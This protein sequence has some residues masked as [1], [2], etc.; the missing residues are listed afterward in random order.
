M[1]SEVVLVALPKGL[2]VAAPLPKIVPVR[3]AL[4]APAGLNVNF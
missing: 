1:A 4:L 3:L 2:V